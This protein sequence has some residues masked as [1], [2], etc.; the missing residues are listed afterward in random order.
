MQLRRCSKKRELFLLFPRL[1][2]GGRCSERT[3]Y[4]SR[5]EAQPLVSS[6]P[7]LLFV[8]RSSL[9]FTHGMH[10]CFHRTPFQS[11]FQTCLINQELFV[12]QNDKRERGRVFALSSAVRLCISHSDLLHRSSSLACAV[13]TINL[14]KSILS[15]SALTRLPRNTTLNADFQ[16]SAHGMYGPVKTNLVY[17]TTVIARAR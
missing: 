14:I 13:P 6:S 2:A 8:L 10:F 17:G 5:F 12:E 9:L 3:I 15:C 7:K 16:R 11:L 4:F 1:Q